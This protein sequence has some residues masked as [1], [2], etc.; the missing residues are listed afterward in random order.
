MPSLHVGLVYG[1]LS[2][3]HDISI[4]SARNVRRAL[5]SRHRVTPIY[6]SRYGTWHIAP[7]RELSDQP[8]AMRPLLAAP[9]QGRPRRGV[10]HSPR[11]ERRGWARAGV[12]PDPRPPVRR[13]RRAGVGGVHGQGRREAVARGRGPAGDALADP[14]PRRRPRVRRGR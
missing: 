13:P 10:P 6:I 4:R 7:D 11:T 3:E 8:S 9:M 14:P 5:G 1:G 12:P 2:S